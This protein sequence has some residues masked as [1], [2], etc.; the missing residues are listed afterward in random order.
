MFQAVVQ[1]EPSANT[2]VTDTLERMLNW[3]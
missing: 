1:D 3:K 2:C